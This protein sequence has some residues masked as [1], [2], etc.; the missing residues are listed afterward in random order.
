MDWELAGPEHELMAGRV[1][2]QAPRVFAMCELERDD[3]GELLDGHIYAWGLAFDGT[4]QWSTPDGTVHGISDS[5]DR[6]MRR[7]WRSAEVGIVWA[8]RPTAG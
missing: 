6:P 4:V 3:E 5:L 2:E 1:A 7:M 8:E